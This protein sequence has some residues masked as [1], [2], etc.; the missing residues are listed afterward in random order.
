MDNNYGGKANSLALLRKNKY[1]VPEFFVVGNDCF[2]EYLLDN[3]ILIETDDK[4]EIRQKI[5]AGE[6]NEKRV[7]EIKQ[8][9]KD[10][11]ADLVSIRSSANVEDGKF[12]S[13]AGQFDTFLNVKEDNLFDYIKK[14]FASFFSENV[15]VYSKEKRLSG[16]NVIVQKMIQS[17]YS[18][19]VFTINPTSDTDNYLLIE[20]TKGLGEKLVGGEITP[21]KYYVRRKTFDIDF[22]TKRE[23]INEKFIKEL[24]RI[25]LKIEKLYSRPMDIEFSVM[26]NEIYIL[27]A[28]PITS[29]TPIPKR[30]VYTLSRPISLIFTE[31]YYE[32]EYNIRKLIKGL[33][34][35]KPLFVYN[36]IKDTSEVYYNYTDFEEIPEKIFYY[37]NMYFSKLMNELDKA[38]KLAIEVEQIYNNKKKIVSI[39]R[40]A[41]KLKKLYTFVSLGQIVGQLGIDVCGEAVYTCLKSFREKY[42]N[43]IYLAHNY[44]MEIVKEY[45]EVKYKPYVNYLLVEEIDNLPSIEEL[46]KRQNG[47]IYYGKVYCEDK[48][49]FERNNNVYLEND[50]DDNTELVGNIAYPGNV[51]GRVVLVF[52]EKDIKK[53][54]ENDIIVSPMTTPKFSNIISSCKAI[55][56]DEG[57]EVCHAAIVAR[58]LKIPCVVGCKRATKVLKDGDIVS[59]KNNK[60]IKQD[61]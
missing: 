40:Y 33:Y 4:E 2:E 59:I 38:I 10:L 44:L 48:D 5:I 19:V 25:S 51:T 17:E 21:E 56:T 57:G 11:D 49:N 6:F 27:Q 43:V 47:Y 34:Y 35:M 1:N 15:E 42:D 18:G 55:I 7:D 37:L 36:P 50:I 32:G 23:Y 29:I 12:K 24:A 28:R 58:E 54:K 61:I 60:I 30:F 26:S 3:G 39:K 53:Y 20:V 13:F 31:I 14:C 45:V 46:K 8:K 9:F 16:M 52:G 22:E 41:D